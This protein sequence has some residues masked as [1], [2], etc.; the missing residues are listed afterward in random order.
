MSEDEN[1]L[2]RTWGGALSAS[3]KAVLSAYARERGPYMGTAPALLVIDVTEAFVGPDAPV[4]Q[5]QEISRQ[6]CGEWAWRALPQ[7]ARLIELFRERRLTVIFT[8]PDPN[9]TWVG[10]ATRGAAR[11]N[12]GDSGIIDII[13]PREDETVLLKAKASAFFG[14]PLISGLI[15]E[16][17]DS[18]VLVGGTTSGCIRATAVDATSYGLEVLVPEDAVFDR[19][20]LSHSVSLIDIEVKYGRVHTTEEIVELVGRA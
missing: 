7:I 20:G 1:R 10:A 15:N 16:G 5:A 14:T 4:E 3:D 2:D 11:S 12:D 18:V 17:H 6:A 13:R 19:V 9:Q 8:V